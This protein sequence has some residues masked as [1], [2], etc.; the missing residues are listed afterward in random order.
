MENLVCKTMQTVTPNKDVKSPAT[1][2]VV[3]LA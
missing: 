3:T 2:V 1:V